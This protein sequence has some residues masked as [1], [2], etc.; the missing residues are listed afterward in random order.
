MLHPQPLNPPAD[1]V[2]LMAGSGK[3]LR[4]LRNH[5]QIIRFLLFPLQG[6]NGIFQAA[7]NHLLRAA[8]RAGNRGA[9]PPRF[10][11]D[12]SGLFPFQPAAFQ[13]LPLRG[14][15]LLLNDLLQRPRQ[16]AN[17]LPVALFLCGEK[18]LPGPALISEM[19][20][21]LL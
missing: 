17:R 10:P 12:L 14:A 21:P 4:G 1:R 18:R 15:Q 5:L 20:P 8:Q 16:P 9:A 7:V 3:H 11:R 19:I 2:A 6:Q 13:Q